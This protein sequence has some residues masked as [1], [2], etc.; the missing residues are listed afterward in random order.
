[1]V[2]MYVKGIPLVGVTPPERAEDLHI[3]MRSGGQA[4]CGVQR[5][6]IQPDTSVLTMAF[7]CSACETALALYRSVLGTGE[8]S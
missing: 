2:N 6:V 7:I 8:A 3:T 5:Q 4:L 1:M